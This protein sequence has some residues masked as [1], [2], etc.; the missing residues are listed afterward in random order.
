ME[1]SAWNKTNVKSLASSTSSKFSDVI[2][3]ILDFVCTG[4]TS[5]TTT[6]RRGYMLCCSLRVCV[7]CVGMCWNSKKEKP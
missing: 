4:M 2:S 5:S 3:I 7:Y 1:G 6:N